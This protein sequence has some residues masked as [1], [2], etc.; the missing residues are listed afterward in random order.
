LHHKTFDDGQ[1]SRGGVERLTA[2]E[3]GIQARD[4]GRCTSNA[5]RIGGKGITVKRVGKINTMA[6]DVIMKGSKTSKK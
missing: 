1:R 3:F 5:A 6:S 2:T 4:G